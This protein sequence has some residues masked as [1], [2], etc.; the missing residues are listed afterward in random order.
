MKYEK[1]PICN[2]KGLHVSVCTMSKIA[3]CRYCR[4]SWSVARWKVTHYKDRCPDCGAE[5]FSGDTVFPHFCSLPQD[6]ID[7]FIE[8]E[9][10]S[11]LRKDV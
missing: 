1:C 5:P 2:K 6:R 4:S 10:R 8:R 7:K 9:K 3:S 11:W